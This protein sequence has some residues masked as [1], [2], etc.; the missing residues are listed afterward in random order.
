[1]KEADAKKK[2]TTATK[3]KR[4]KRSCN[5]QKVRE[6]ISRLTRQ[7]PNK[8]QTQQ[9]HESLRVCMCECECVCGP[10][11]NGSN[12]LRLVAELLINNQAIDWLDRPTIINHTLMTVLAQRWPVRCLSLLF[13]GLNSSNRQRQQR[14]VMAVNLFVDTNFFSLFFCCRC[15]CCCCCCC[16]CCC[17][18]VA[19]AH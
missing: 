3:T 11:S 13:C 4:K 7:M 2:R 6:T 1:M 12:M 15:R 5:Y 17:C 19:R 18:C 14:R 8:W 9:L 10:V 16:Q